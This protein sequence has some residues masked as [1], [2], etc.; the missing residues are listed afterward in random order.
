ME[1]SVRVRTLS[2]SRPSDLIVLVDSDFSIY[3]L[4]IEELWKEWEW[5]ERFPGRQE[6]VDYFAYVDKK[7]DLKRD[8]SFDTRVT[9]AYFDSPTDRCVV[10]T[11][12]HR[13]GI[14][15]A[16]A[17]SSSAPDLRPSP[18]PRI[19][20]ARRLPRHHPPHS[21]M[22]VRPI[23][24]ILLLSERIARFATVAELSH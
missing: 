13:T 23:R 2:S 18:L 7:L 3:Q 5:T 8:M 19:Q 21:P 17:S 12:R 6:L 4:S 14:P 9:A 24:R 11:S 20:G 1:C 15:S 22:A 10:S 16:P